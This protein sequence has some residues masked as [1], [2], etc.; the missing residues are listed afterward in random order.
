MRAYQQPIFQ[1]DDATI[2]AVP[3]LA[4]TIEVA[5]DQNRPAPRAG[6][7]DL[8]IAVCCYFSGC[9][10][11]VWFALHCQLYGFDAGAAHY[12]AA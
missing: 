6:D 12:A 7:L 2:I 11:N 8:G 10:L 9:G 1:E 4:I 3:G 5:Q